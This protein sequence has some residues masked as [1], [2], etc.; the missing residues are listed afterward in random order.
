M[1]SYRSVVCLRLLVHPDCLISSHLV[2]AYWFDCIVQSPLSPL[3]TISGSY[4]QSTTED[5]LSHK[6]QAAIYFSIP[7]VKASSIRSRLARMTEGYVPSPHHIPL[8]R[9]TKEQFVRDPP[10]PLSVTGNPLL[11]FGGLVKSRT[12]DRP[13]SNLIL[14]TTLP[15][16]A[17]CAPIRCQ[18][19]MEK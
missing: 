1:G 10:S 9:S 15:P 4:Q 8:G 12:L 7:F 14:S 17:R 19:Y 16:I 2:N 3:G 13:D 11:E 5:P 18:T 6:A